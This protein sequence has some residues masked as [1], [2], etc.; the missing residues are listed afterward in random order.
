MT[1]FA[2]RHIR[3]DSF[4]CGNT[5]DFGVEPSDTGGDVGDG[6]AVAPGAMSLAGEQE[7][8]VALAG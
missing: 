7:D 4:D 1:D 2:C 8:G 6:D 5:W 3:V